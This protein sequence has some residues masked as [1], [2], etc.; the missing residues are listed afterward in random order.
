MSDDV[1]RPRG[2]VAQAI[3]DAFRAEAKKR[4]GRPHSAWVEAER[5][6]VWSAARDEA[7]K[8][9]APVPTMRD[10]IR[11]DLIAMGHSDYGAR[12]ARGVACIIEQS[13]P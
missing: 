8:I 9:G 5:Y 7:K 3:Y 10:V 4:D 13:K 2:V 1:F 6:A 11:E 12:W